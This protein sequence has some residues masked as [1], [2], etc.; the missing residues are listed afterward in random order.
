MSDLLQGVN[1]YL[2]GMMGAGK[3]TVGQLLARELGYR[4]LDTDRVIEQT[5]GQSIND[6]F[7][8]SGETAFRDLEA[9]VLAQLSAYTKLIIATGGGIVLRSLNWSYLHHGVVIWLDAPVEQLY[10]RLQDDTSRPLLQD[11]DPKAKLQAILDDRHSLYAQ[12]DLRVPIHRSDTPEDVSQRILS[13]L[14]NRMRSDR[15]RKV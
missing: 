2:V 1:L 5:T 6:I 13:E 9:Q 15:D 8:T 4:F 10:D 12:A 3:T 11:P 14:P 7:A